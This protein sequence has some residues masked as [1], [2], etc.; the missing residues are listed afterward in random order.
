MGQVR[1]ARQW[2]TL[3]AGM[4]H[5]L[6]IGGDLDRP[7]EE[8]RLARS[9][10]DGDGSAFAALYDRYESTIFNYCQRLVG[11]GEDAADATHEAFA[12]VLQRLPELDEDREL[13]F[14][15]CLYT[16]ARN[17]SY[18]MIGRR[19]RAEP[20]DAIPEP[21]SV[22]ADGLVVGALDEDPER[23]ALLASFQEDVRAASA[24]LGDRHREV[25]A[26][27]ELDE[28]SYDEIAG[29]MVMNGNSV[30]Q[31]ISRARIKL[32]DELRGSAL[33]AIAVSSP[34]CERA[35]ALV[36][37]R[38]D[39]QLRDAQ[40][41]AWLEAHLGACDTCRASVEA[42]EEAGVSYRVWAPVVPLAWLRQATIERAGELVG[43]DWSEVARTPW[44]AEPDGASADHDESEGEQLG[45]EPPLRHPAAAPLLRHELPL[46][47]RAAALLLGHDHDRG[48]EVEH[49]FAQDN[50]DGWEAAPVVVDE[51]ERRR[52]RAALIG[53]LVLLLVLIGAV[54]FVLGGGSGSENAGRGAPPPRRP[55]PVAPDAAAAP[56]PSTGSGKGAKRKRRKAESGGAVVP[57]AGSG[58]GGGRIPANPG[59]AGP[60]VPPPSSNEPTPT[61]PGEPDPA[62]PSPT[63]TTPAPSTT[64]PSPPTVTPPPTVPTTETPPSQP[65]GTGTPPSGTGTPSHPGGRQPGGP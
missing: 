12:G 32:R 65:P 48:A 43:E 4:G 23:A 5:T 38:Q 59:S 56:A 41:R 36:S 52:R 47:R 30:A 24:R 62:D 42:I 16:A 6:Q 8:E 13:S 34:E 14:A 29:I 20:V 21:P 11:G 60:P 45:H 37:M 17:A 61:T 44:D 51:E 50:P 53:G 39:G 7:A 25:L 26:L 40:D 55:P 9:A 63:K 10:A 18:D 49:D 19:E 31:L 33:A 64:D 35:L 1:V 46:R 57:G 3:A 28:L 54:A 27:R 15:A 2:G 58:A 22:G